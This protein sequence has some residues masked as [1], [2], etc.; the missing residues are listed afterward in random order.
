MATRYEYEIQG[1]YHGS[2]EMLTT[3][4]T[5]RQAREQLKVYQD[6]ERGV[7]LRIKKIKEAN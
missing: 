7:P 6:N 4:E 1:Y 2:W 5:L 3:E